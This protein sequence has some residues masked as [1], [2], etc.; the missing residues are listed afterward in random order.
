[1]EKSEAK[2]R[3]K[4]KNYTERRLQIAIIF[5]FQ[6][7]NLG[8]QMLKRRRWVSQRGWW[9]VRTNFCKNEDIIRS[10]AVAYFN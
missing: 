10:E 7:Q 1:M 6:G 9:M 2:K 8:R 5:L 4:K 3:K